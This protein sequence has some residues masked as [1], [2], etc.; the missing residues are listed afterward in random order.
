[1]VE[2]CHISSKV[3][4]KR[5]RKPLIVVIYFDFNFSSGIYLKKIKKSNGNG[6][7]EHTTVMHMHIINQYFELEHYIFI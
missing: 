5:V 3:K 2:R 7:L 6:N 4:T 1:M